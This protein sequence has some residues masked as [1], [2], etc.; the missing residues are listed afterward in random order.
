MTQAKQL[1]SGNWRI[2]IYDSTLPTPVTK[3]FTAET[4]KKAE[5]LASQYVAE[6]ERRRLGFAA[7]LD[8]TQIDNRKFGDCLDEWI[9]GRSNVLSPS[10]VALYKN[11][12]KKPIG[13]IENVPVNKLTRDRLQ[14]FINDYAKDHKP[15]SV[16][17]VEALLRTSLKDIRPD[18]AFV[19]K[20]PQKEKVDIVI[21]TT[22]QVNN[23]LQASEGT[24]LHLPILLAAFMGMRRSEI[25]ALTWDDV[26]FVNN[27]I[28]VDEA[29][30]Y[31]DD[32]TPVRKTTKTTESHRTLEI[33]QKVRDGFPFLFDDQFIKLTPKQIS[34]RFDTLKRKF[35]Y[36][37]TFHGLRHYYASISLKLNIP[38][39]YVMER[40][41]HSTNVMLKRVYQHTFQD[42]QQEVTRRLNDYF[43]NM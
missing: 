5:F 8:E 25:A 13:R 6:M 39:K 19:V 3:S 24:D 2:R 7:G 17:N 37:F 41:G 30:V 34:H 43:D 42:E 15:K 26:D 4:K 27:T 10:T 12:R 38:D 28:R 29:I 9:E 33:P 20:L 31:D 23:L 14:R 1:P 16:K 36:K 18:F 11:L 22:E 32:D 35:G 21:P 40:M